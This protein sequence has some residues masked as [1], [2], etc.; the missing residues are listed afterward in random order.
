MK[1]RRT[2]PFS[3]YLASLQGALPTSV[4]RT[5]QGEG[6]WAEPLE[7]ACQ[8]LPLASEYLTTVGLQALRVSPFG[9][10]TGRE[11]KFLAG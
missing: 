6:L 4:R 7:Q 8:S 11:Q 10:G 9:S 1:G 3:A 2:A 5:Q